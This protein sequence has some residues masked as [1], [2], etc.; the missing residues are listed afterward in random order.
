MPTAETMTATDQ[1]PETA[2]GTTPDPFA[3]LGMPARFDLDLAELERHY[4][5]QSRLVHPDRFATAPAAERVVALTRARA[6]NDAYKLLRK[7]TSRAE[8]LLVR[9][10]LAIG[11]REQLDPAFLM[12]ILDLRESLSEATARAE[13]PEVARLQGEMVAR[14]KALLADLTT[15]ATAGAWPLAKRVLISLRYVDRYLEAC[16]VA[17][18]DS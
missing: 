13:L 3:L 9:A 14:R 11:D 17:L 4:H 15:H 7:P 16:D 18:E 12:E 6:L 8:H 1:L 5:E 2:R 10:G